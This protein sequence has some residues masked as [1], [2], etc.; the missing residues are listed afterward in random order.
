MK[1]LLLSVLT[2]V[3]LAVPAQARERRHSARGVG[4][5][6]SPTEFISEGNATHLG[7]FHEVGGVQFTPT[8]DPVVVHID[9]WAIHTA[10]NGE[11]LFE[12]ISGEL[13]LQT[14][15]GAATMTYVGGTGRFAN[16]TGSA[17]FSL[18]LLGDGAFKYAGAGVIDY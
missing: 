8:A 14:G 18:Q 3:V 10:A 7:R 12:V 17:R 2:L 6:V 13:N 1:G 4:Q 16:A 15:A 9:G 5:F 11:Q